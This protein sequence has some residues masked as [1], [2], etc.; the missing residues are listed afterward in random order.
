[1]KPLIP[2]AMILA[3]AQSAQA[4]DIEAGKRMAATVCAACHGETGISVSETV[5]NLAAQRARIGKERKQNRRPHDG[6][7]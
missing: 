5:P 3:A 2:F 7:G 6:A 1:M 4:A